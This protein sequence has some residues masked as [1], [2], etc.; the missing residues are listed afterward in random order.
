MKLYH[1]SKRLD[2]VEQF[3]PRIPE[4]RIEREDDTV[5]RICVSKSVGGCLSAVPDGGSELEQYLFDTGGFVQV[6][7]FDTHTLGLSEE[8]VIPPDVLY[9]K[10]WVEDAVA[11]GEH[12]IT[13]PVK[14]TESYWLL[15][16][17]WMD[18]EIEFYP[19][20]VEKRMNSGEG[21]LDAFEAVCP[22]RR[23][24]QYATKID[25]IDVYQAGFKKG[26]TFRLCYGCENDYFDRRVKEG[27]YPGVRRLS[28]RYFE[29]QETFTLRELWE[30][31]QYN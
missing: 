5:K 10:G 21:F 1:V 26:E 18:S 29:A 6:F 25:L 17:D 20:E 7:V 3:A 13:V 9:Q 12:W 22:E 8:E 2:D 16:G 27:Q 19:Y 4:N 15:I 14:P 30:W 28:E 31:I 11:T 23:S 24:L